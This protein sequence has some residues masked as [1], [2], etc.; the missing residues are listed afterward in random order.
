MS[1]MFEFIGICALFLLALR[2]S[3]FFSGAETG[4]YRLSFVRLSI[5]AN[6]G[7]R[8]AQRIFW[9]AQNPSYFVATTLVGI[10]VASYLMTLAIGL[11][12]VRLHGDSSGWAE[13]AATILLSPV[14]FVFGELVPKNL[15]YRAP[16]LLLRRGS[17]WMSFFFRLFLVDSFPLITITKLIERFGGSER[18]NMELVLGRKRLVQVLS[19]GHQEGLLT[20]VQGRLVQ[21][22]LHTA[23]QPVGESIT[24]MNR[25]L[26]VDVGASR[27]E[28]LEFAR[29]FGLVIVAVK[30]AGTEDGWYGY[31]RVSDVA[32][33]QKPLAASIQEMPRLQHGIS[34][35]ETL[36]EL[37]RAG[38][39]YGVICDG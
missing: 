39:E 34:K 9:F 16:L 11:A 27:D 32:I 18:P 21:G 7:D 37:Q 36:L 5:D 13:V 29:K 22:M 19:Q 30:R 20:D 33:A 35:L 1:Q 14:I 8:V 31:L 3:A 4:F 24:P 25:I 6:A 17:A 23:A 2:L 12:V 10:N 28:V 26:G 38:A 15:Y